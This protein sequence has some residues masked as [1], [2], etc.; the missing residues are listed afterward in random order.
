MIITFMLQNRKYIW[1]NSF[2]TEKPII[3]LSSIKMH[4]NYVHI[5]DGLFAGKTIAV[6][7]VCWVNF[8]LHKLIASF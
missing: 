8:L 2:T 4:K 1:N 6:N 3:Q 7:H 5:F